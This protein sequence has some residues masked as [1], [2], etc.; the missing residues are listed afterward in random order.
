MRAPAQRGVD[1]D[2]RRGVIIVIVISG[3]GGGGVPPTTV[4]FKGVTP[5]RGTSV[6]YRHGDLQR[7]AA[8]QHPGVARITVTRSDARSSGG[9]R[10]FVLFGCVYACMRVC[11]LTFSAV[12]GLVLDTSPRRLPQN[13]SS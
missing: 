11:V 5:S 8:V 6:P 2:R 13:R 1:G 10:C 3:G 7:A 12:H 9:D 4:A